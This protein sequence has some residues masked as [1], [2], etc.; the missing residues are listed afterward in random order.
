MQRRGA[1]DSVDRGARE[2]YLE[3]QGDVMG[4]MSDTA[5][6]SGRVGGR[7]M[8]AVAVVAA[9]AVG[10]GTGA[11]LFR[12]SAGEAPGGE[13][14]PSADHAEHE[15]ADALAGLSLSAGGYTLSPISAP[16][17]V[18]EDAVL[19]FAIIDPAGETLRKY[20]TAHDRELHVMIVRSDGQHFRHVHP[21]RDPDTGV[22]SLP[23]SWDAAGSYRLFADA[24]PGLAG[25]EPFTLARAIEVSGTYEPVPVALSR[26][27]QI[28][29]YTVSIAGDL[30]AGATSELVATVTRE[31]APVTS[32][33]PYLGAF[34]H[35]VALRE[36][37]QAYLH[38]HAE[39]EEAVEGQ[40]TGPDIVFSATAPTAGLYQL[41]LDIQI[42][43]V[44]HTAA[45]VLDAAPGETPSGH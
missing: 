22:W 35:L 18:G 40:N 6:G 14:M 37:D 28:D 26:T 4:E 1:P 5:Q 45:F 7:G 24:T 23:W 44:V 16:T 38:V 13:A 10:F 21:T 25:A 11:L 3:S 15:T 32:L 34:G 12:A 17:Q 42:D 8:V 2:G 33:E 31:G 43:D 39:G 41:Y 27:A 20:E 29:G 36:G 9:L 19:S 30:T